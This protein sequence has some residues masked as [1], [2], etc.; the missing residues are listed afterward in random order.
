ML[1]RISMVLILLF[2]CDVR[3][4]CQQLQPISCLHFPVSGLGESPALP[5]PAPTL[6]YRHIR[7]LHSRAQLP[8]G[9]GT[10]SAPSHPILAPVKH[11]LQRAPQC[12]LPGPGTEVQSVRTGPCVGE[13]RPET[14]LKLLHLIRTRGVHSSGRVI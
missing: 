11:A 2:R 5:T 8:P 13:K 9:T 10:I 4:S 12:S 3:E 14:T 6:P 1:C 7:A